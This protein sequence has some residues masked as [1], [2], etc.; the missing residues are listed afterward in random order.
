[1]LPSRPIAVLSLLSIAVAASGRP[2]ADVSVKVINYD[3]LSALVKQHHGKVVVVDFWADY[4]VPCKR[5]FPNLVAMHQKFGK[6]GLVAISVSLD[7]LSE[8]GTKDKVIAFL[9]K[10][11]ATMIN[12][13][14]DE[15]PEIWQAKLKIDGPP[16][17]MV[18]NRKGELEQKFIDK[19]VD[20]TAI[21][22]VAAELLKK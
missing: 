17:V 10:Q 8:N 16:L 18:F 1:M 19:D 3:A 6:D 7:D 5:E 13:I 14:L 22:K 9:Q 12:L 4:C 20:Y 21:E 15:K 2:P 11:Q